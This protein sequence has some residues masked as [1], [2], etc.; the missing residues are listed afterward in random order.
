MNNGVQRR[1]AVFAVISLVAVA[2]AGARYARLT[3]RIL[4]TT[5]EVFAELASSGGLYPGA[6][7]TYRGV[8]VG[9][10]T[11][12]RL[13]RIGVT[14]RLAIR[15]QWKIPSP[16]T[17]AV[18]NRSAVGE[19]YIDLTPG[20]ARNGNLENGATIPRERTSIPLP[21]ETLVTSLD[22][23]MESINKNDLH[24]VVSELNEATAGRA[25]D[26]SRV[27]AHT[28]DLVRASNEHLPE[29]VSLLRNA[30]TVLRTQQA[31]ASDLKILARGLAEVTTTLRARDGEIR[32]VIDRGSPAA[33][34]LTGLLTDLRVPTHEL[35][36]R[37]RVLA[38]MARQNLPG[39]AQFLS[40]FPW[41][42]ATIQP[43]ARGGRAHLSLTLSPF[44][45]AC[46]RGYIDP[47]QWRST[48]DLTDLGAIFGL[49]CVE[50]D[51]NWRG[52][53]QIDR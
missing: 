29:T 44:P 14:A 34:Q 30:A 23:L 45:T 7:V 47:S 41:D 53:A 39:I 40:I 48:Q 26:I 13:D 9:K 33:T 8:P 50:P 27:L 25:E 28:D 11:D 49:R 12:V 32:A 1:I 15:N 35:L 52:T 16:V 22:E 17:A 4:P 6:E 2:F 21:E 36:S 19:Q 46:Q 3:D 42:V 5:Y 18:H 37:V 10:V 51:K 24:T 20:T 31:G 43:A 38:Q